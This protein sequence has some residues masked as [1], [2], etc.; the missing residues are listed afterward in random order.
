MPRPRVKVDFRGSHSLKYRQ[1][2]SIVKKLQLFNLIVAETLFKKSFSKDFLKH[3]YYGIYEK[4]M[5][6][7]QEHRTRKT[8]NEQK[9][10]TI[11]K[12]DSVFPG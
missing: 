5:N 1:Q 2:Y 4:I 8:W 6:I 11:C 3:H 7:F 10:K 9:H 12:Y